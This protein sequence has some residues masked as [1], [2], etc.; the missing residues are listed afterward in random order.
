M[1]GEQHGAVLRWY[2]CIGDINNLTKQML[3]ETKAVKHM[4]VGGNSMI[5]VV[6]HL[7]TSQARQIQPEHPQPIGFLHSTVGTGQKSCK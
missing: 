1:R 4:V 5:V 3:N 2:R 6:A 7:M